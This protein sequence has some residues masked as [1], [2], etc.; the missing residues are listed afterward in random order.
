M[1]KHILAKILLVFTIVMV[2]VFFVTAVSGEENPWP[3]YWAEKR[4]LE[5]LPPPEFDRP[6]KGE[7]T[8]IRVKSTADVRAG[9]WISHNFADPIA[10]ATRRTP[11]AFVS[12]V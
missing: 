11:I 4:R 6:Y 1:T 9:C 7:L 8:I 3:K 2:A 10:C 12:S 5:I